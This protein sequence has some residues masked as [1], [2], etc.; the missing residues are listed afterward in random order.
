VQGGKLK[1]QYLAEHDVLVV[2]V[3]WALETENDVER[4]EE[5][6]ASYFR[7]HFKRKVDV[8]LELTRFRIHPRIARR[9]GEVR[10]KILREY[11]T[12]SYRVNAD[13]VVKTAMYTSHVLYSA[14]ANEFRTIDAALRQIATDRARER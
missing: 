14:P 3:N 1:I 2:T 11:T 13:S 4:W 6:Y 9:F 7:T 10:A 12:R 8:I 5:A